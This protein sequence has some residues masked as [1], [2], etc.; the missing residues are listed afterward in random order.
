MQKRR[1]VSQRETVLPEN[2]DDADIS[3]Q[4]LNAF[5]ERVVEWYKKHGR[6]NLLW[7][8]T[9]DPWKVLVAAFL[10]RKTTSKQVEKIYLDFLMRFPTPADVQKSSEEEIKS[11]IR[12]LGIENQ[13][14]R[15][16]KKIASII[17]HEFNGKIPCSKER[18]KKLPG[19]GDY[20]AAE[21]LLA[22]CG[23]PEP[24]LD[25]NMI[26]VIERF[27]G[28]RSSKKRPHTDPELWRFAKKL[29]PESADVA[30]DFNY[31][32][33]DLAQTVCTAKNPNCGKCPLA[34][35]CSYVCRAENEER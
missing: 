3:P 30:K 15:H 4:K 21:V 5:S 14:A 28:I 23:K 34:D 19:V 32:V 2:V 1:S 7:R 31:G 6:K 10:L 20:I 27:F 22:A 25:R 11:I 26:R 17:M 29:V 18:L 24:L 35:L 13:R 9:K 8:R 12:P 33:L 16:L